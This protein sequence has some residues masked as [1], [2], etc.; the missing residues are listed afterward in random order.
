[1]FKV[2]EKGIIEEGEPWDITLDDHA[3]ICEIF[4]AVENY[5]PLEKIDGVWQHMFEDNHTKR[6]L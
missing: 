5:S 1:M 4:T 2:T 6:L 3:E